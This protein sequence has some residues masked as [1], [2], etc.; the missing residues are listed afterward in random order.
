MEAILVLTALPKLAQA[1]ALARALVEAHEAACV[2]RAGPLRSV[3]RWAEAVEEAEEYLLLIKTRLDCYTAVESR[4]RAMHPYTVPEVISI[5]L[6]HIEPR[7]LAW[8][9]E[10]LVSGS[11]A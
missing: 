9:N 1:E 4:I 11:R 10:S 2:S 3:Y 6:D 5:R 8:L 7:Y